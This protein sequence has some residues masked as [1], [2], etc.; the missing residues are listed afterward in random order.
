MKC[1]LLNYIKDIL[2][3]GTVLTVYFKA[4]LVHEVNKFI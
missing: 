2:N 3:D 4:V 1:D